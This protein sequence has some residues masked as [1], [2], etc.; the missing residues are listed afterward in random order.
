MMKYIRQIIT[1]IIVIIILVIFIPRNAFK[2]QEKRI[3]ITQYYLTYN[4]IDIKLNTD[5]SN[6]IATLDSYND[7]RESDS[8]T[9][10]S[11]Y[12]Y[13]KFQI[14]TYYD[15]NIERVKSIL[16]TSEDIYTNEGLGIGDSEKYII[17]TYNQPTRY[18]NNIYYYELNDTSIS[19]IVEN[20]KII[21]I[22]YNIT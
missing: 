18:N 8:N 12:Y 2:S 7:S 10:G 9:P 13:D 19:F 5:F 11:I 20:N 1:F 3:E 4:N 15:G 14:E 16:F 22:E 21:S 17:Q 6:Y